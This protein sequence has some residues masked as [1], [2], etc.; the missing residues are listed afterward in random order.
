MKTPVRI[1]NARLCY[2]PQN[3]S[4]REDC[5]VG[6]CQALA[7]RGAR[8]V[9]VFA[10]EIPSDLARAFQERGVESATIDYGR[11][12]FHYYKELG[13]VV[14]NYSVNA[15][16]ICYFDY[17]SAIAWMAKL[18]GVPTIIYE[19]VNSGVFNA[20]S[21]KRSLLRLRTRIMTKHVTRL[22][23]ISE[24]VKQQ[25]IEGGVSPEK[26]DV[27]RLGV[28]HR[29]FT[30]APEAKSC[31]VKDYLISPDE[32][33]VSTISFLNPFKNPQTILEACGLLARDGI[34]FRL[35]V[36]GDGG[37]MAELKILSRRQGIAD[38]VHWLGHIPDPR[39]LLQGSDIF[40]LASVGE[41]FGL[42]LPEAMACSLPVV[43]TR[44]GGIV[45]IVEEG[46][47][48]FL[49]SPLNPEAFAKALKRLI[50]DRELREYMGKRGQ[51]RVA[52]LFTLDKVIANTMDIY[53]SMNLVE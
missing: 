1:E 40:A 7:A 30:L 31:L 38:R 42:V 34:R 47:T 29:R 22:I 4:S 15:V 2:A 6:V 44:S 28:D 10:K 33:I 27:R 21:W 43:S 11:G 36:A 12:I 17:F 46:V 50:E 18:H 5:H 51:E 39:R 41:A 45:E 19:A 48:G 37:L 14:R 13:K 9:L 49:V 26:I 23:A 52:R 35:F 32:V 25:L 20:R 3:W 53:K 8:S 16:H 24:F